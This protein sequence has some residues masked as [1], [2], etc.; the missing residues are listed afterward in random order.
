[1]S[2]CTGNIAFNT[3][4]PDG[5]YLGQVPI[6]FYKLL[7]ERSLG[8]LIFSV[9]RLNLTVNINIE[10]QFEEDDQN[11]DILILKYVLSIS[12]DRLCTSLC[13]LG[14]QN[15]NDYSKRTYL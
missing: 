9:I 15:L 6:L 10:M 13:F 4:F 2:L 1:M 5:F 3:F 8:D 14:R 11:N 12:E 7:R